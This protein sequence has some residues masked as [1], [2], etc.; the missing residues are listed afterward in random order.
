MY[1]GMVTGNLLEV[2]SVLQLTSFVGEEYWEEFHLVL[3]KNDWI[4]LW[5]GGEVKVILNRASPQ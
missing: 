2:T 4:S 5:E 3:D 1:W